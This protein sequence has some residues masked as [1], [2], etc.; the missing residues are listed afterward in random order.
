MAYKFLAVCGF[1]VGSSMVLKMTLEKVARERGIEVEVETMD[2]SSAKGS[3]ADAIFTSQE[4]GDEL[5][6]SE[7]IPVFPVKR[8]MDKEEVGRAIDDFL[9]THE[10]V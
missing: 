4:L 2:L 7:K 6:R 5:K 1:G 9:A 10:E 8:Y 3:G